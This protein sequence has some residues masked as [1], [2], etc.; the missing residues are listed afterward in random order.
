MITLYRKNETDFT[1]N[2]IC[3]LRDCIVAEVQEEINGA[4]ELYVEYPLDGEK[5]SAIQEERI[6]RV[7]TVQGNQLFR[8]YRK[9]RNMSIVQVYARHIFYDLIDNFIEDTNIVGK[10][11]AAALDQLL[12]NTQYPHSFLVMSDIETIAN[13]RVVRKN[14]VEAI[15]SDDD[16]S[17]F[18]RWGGEIARDNFDIRINRKRGSDKGVSIAYGKNLIGIEEDISLDSVTTRIVPIGF[19]GLMLPEK[20]VDSPLLLNYDRPK[21]KK[22]EFSEIKAQSGDE[23]KEDE[24]PLEQAYEAL[25]VAAKQ[26]FEVAHIDIPSANYKVN[27]IELSKTEE[28]KDFNILECVLIGD[29]V[30]IRHKKLDLNIQ[31]KAISYTWNALVKKYEEIELGNFKNSFVD[32]M[33]A[34]DKIKDTLDNLDTTILES[35]K[36][37]A[38]D[39]INSGFGGFVR[40]HSDRILIMDTEKEETAMC[41]WQWN[42]NG[43]GYSSTGINGPYGLAMT[44]D[45]AIVADFITVGVLNGALLKA[46]SVQ[47]K[48]LSVEVAQTIRKGLAT[49][50]DLTKLTVDVNGLDLVVKK[51]KTDVEG[52]ITSVE[53]SIVAQAGLISQKV[54]ANDFSS[55]IEQ[56]PQAIKFHFETGTF[57][58]NTTKIS[59]NGLKVIHKGSGLYTDISG[60]GMETNKITIKRPD[61]ITVINNGIPSFDFTIEGCSPTFTDPKV[62][63]F[64]YWFR[65]KSPNY[66]DMD[67]Y[68]FKHVGRYLK[69]NVGI[70]SETGVR[71]WIAIYDRDG[72]TKLAE[73][74]HGHWIGSNGG[75]FLFNIDLGA[76]TGNIRSF[77]I[78]FRRDEY[79]PDSYTYVRKIRS[80]LEG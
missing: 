78:R 30:S 72:V 5:Y 13:S 63:I 59:G 21:I 31:A 32:G 24:L 11:G 48:H 66:V 8:I 40:V 2:G 15:M 38:T 52:K 56:N 20:Y 19:D 50:E 57:D 61:G 18:S 51:N 33:A 23:L 41:V 58:T 34:I 49:E 65:T 36:E 10:N 71:G 76:P 42:K 44:K 55:L 64:G 80:W 22:I 74:Y 68:S 35:A 26:L 70:A 4:Y 17:F 12:K 60:E 9:L 7:P 16:N 3:V 14:P 62:D 25:R 6:I 27:F 77:Y 45:G 43:L 1:H 67:F 79:S 37:V 54:S 39:L 53:S 73:T 28:Y 46:G 29:T 75:D 47:T 69:I